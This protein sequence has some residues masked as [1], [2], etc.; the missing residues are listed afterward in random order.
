[1]LILYY[2]NNNNKMIFELCKPYIFIKN[3]SE[4]EDISIFF[5]FKYLTYTKKYT[6][7]N[8]LKN[9]QIVKSIH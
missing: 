9:T 8:Y 2:N 1:M 4:N 3:Y 5:F 7:K 6:Q